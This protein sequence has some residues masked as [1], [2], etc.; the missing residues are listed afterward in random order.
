[1]RLGWIA[2]AG[3]RG[4]RD[5]HFIPDPN[6]NV[7]VG[8]NG[9][10]KSNLLEAIAFLGTARSFRRAP[11]EALIAHD[12]DTAVLRGEVGHGERMVLIEMEIVRKGG[13]KLQ[14]NRKRQTRTADLAEALRVVTFL[15]DDLEI[16]KG[17][18]GERRD[19]LD[20][21]AALI[22][23]SAALDQA[24]FD[25]ALR[26][27]NAFLRRHEE[28]M[29]TL[30]VWDQRLA[31]AGGRLMERRARAAA[32]IEK[33]AAEAY[34]RIAGRDTTVAFTYRSEWGGSLDPAIPASDHQEK[35]AEALQAGRRTDRERGLTT[36]G[37]QRDEP[38]ITLG[39]YD[40][41][42]HGSQGEQRSMALSLRLA[43]H[44]A[45]EEA[46]TE[47]PVLVLDDV[48]SELDPRRA[49]SLVASLPPVQTFISTAHSEDVPLTGRRFQ[50]EDGTIS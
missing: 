4:Y 48:F 22:W 14:V 46:S 45:V 17:G 7:L 24:E 3:F 11:D 1:M 2:L 15:P 39:E 23:P 30:E 41:R 38:A 32:L 5:L 40:L 36:S 6:I 18:P 10:G 25:R 13:R 44:R 29:A 12:A 21:A 37:P 8:A 20:Q 50:V 43:T 34:Q 35:L 47:V 31:E 26:Q 42:Y 27:R 16:V 28:D 33:P 9:A 49:D 19:L